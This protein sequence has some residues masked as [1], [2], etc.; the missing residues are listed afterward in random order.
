MC[1]RVNLSFTV[2]TYCTHALHR[3]IRRLITMHAERATL[4]ASHEAAISQARSASAEV[5]RRLEQET[6]QG[7]EVS[8]GEG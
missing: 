8:G 4:E 3:V 6:Q 5:T 7:G 2:I 1:E